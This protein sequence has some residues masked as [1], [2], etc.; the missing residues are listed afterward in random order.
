MML[1]FS[2]APV[3]FV[4]TVLLVVRVESWK[5]TT[6]TSE[7]FSLRY[8]DRTSFNGCYLEQLPSFSTSTPY[9]PNYILNGWSTAGRC[10]VC[11]SSQS[12]YDEV[13]QDSTRAIKKAPSSHFFSQNSLNDTK[14]VL[15]RDDFR[16]NQSNTTGQT[17]TIDII[18]RDLCRG[19]DIT[20]PSKIQSLAWPILLKGKNAIVADQT[21]SGKT[22]AYL[23]PL[24]QRA[25]SLSN[26]A[27]L[28][29]NVLRCKRRKPGMP[30]ILILTPTAELADQTLAVCDRLAQHVPLRNMVLSASGQYN[31]VIHDQVRRLQRSQVDILI[32]T[33]GRLATILRSRQS[34]LKL[35]QLVAVVFDEVDMLLLD[36]SFRDQL[37]IVGAA[38][39]AERTQFVFV[40]AT[41]PDVVV[42]TINREFNIGPRNTVAT[43]RGPGL[44]LV[45]PSVQTKLVDV[46]IP[47]P[48]SHRITGTKLYSASLGFDLKAEALLSALRHNKCKRTLV[49]CNT[50]ETCRKVE[51]LLRRSDRRGLLYKVYVYHNAL[52]S[53][54][55]NHNLLA[56]S[57]DHTI[58]SD[59]RSNESHEN[60]ITK[61]ATSDK[62][63]SKDSIE[64]ILVCTDR[65]AR[66]VDFDANPVDHVVIF[67]F[68]KDPADYVRRVGRTARAGRTG[69]STIL[70]YG[71]QLP[72][73]R[74]AITQS[75]SSSPLKT[76]GIQ[77][78]LE[79]EFED[80]WIPDSSGM[81]GRLRAV[82]KPQGKTKKD[83]QSLSSIIARGQQWT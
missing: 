51:N 79:T 5:P 30:L 81:Q 2:V 28:Q 10:L 65:A 83:D 24:L 67:D 64:S 6:F 27:S 75:T 54:V 17:E 37:Q 23:I 3:A 13:N 35:N 15:G 49:F 48:D 58:V 46:S 63:A 47:T 19:V 31:T 39:P 45:A 66:G 40:T 33:P 14:F 29:D 50:I 11:H 60:K 61:R 44:H 18:F 77:T 59:T 71:W 76:T 34:G 52:T 82:K 4:V 73:A 32:S 36:K 78:S 1:E 22:L 70:A 72:I 8:Q 68:P 43:I 42:D 69:V 80:K 62:I 74:Q 21:G 57:R 20:R 53:E 55:R 56:F 41:L 38:T 7:D 26:I 9:L 12:A 16:R 25:L